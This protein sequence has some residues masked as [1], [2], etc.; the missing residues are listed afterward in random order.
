MQCMHGKA[1]RRVDA[2]ITEMARQEIANCPQGKAMPLHPL[3]HHFTLNVIREVIFGQVRPTCW[4]ELLGLLKQMMKF[5]DKFTSVMMI[6]KMS[7]RAVRLLTAIR[8]L[9]LHDF[10]K[11]R[12]RVDALIAEA[13]EERRKVGVQ[14]I[15][16]LRPPVPTIIVREVMK[17]IEIGGGRGWS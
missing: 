3:I 17:P 4:E 9:G 2:T 1:L 10:L 5:V 6:H 13:V 15:L 12:E 14:E 11:C 8:P 7:P 16:R